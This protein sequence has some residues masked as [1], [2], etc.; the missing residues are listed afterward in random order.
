MRVAVRI[1]S[2]R[3]GG[4]LIAD[5]CRSDRH[6][7]DAVRYVRLNAKNVLRMPRPCDAFAVGRYHFDARQI[8][9]RVGRAVYAFDPLR[10]IGVEFT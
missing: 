9:D 3:V 6:G 1:H 10:V 7:A 2:G 5:V 8:L 4:R